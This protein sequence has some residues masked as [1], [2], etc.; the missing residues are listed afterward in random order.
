MNFWIGYYLFSLA[1]LLFTIFSPKYTKVVLAIYLFSIWFIGAFRYMYGADYYMYELLF[2]SGNADAVLFSAP[3]IEPTF[4]MMVDLYN[5][6]GLSY[7]A[8]FVTYET[9]ILFFFYKG[10]DVFFQ[11]GRQRLMMTLLYA[12]T[13]LTGGYF[14]GLNGMRQAAAM[15]ILFFASKYVLSHDLKRF[16]IF[17]TISVLFHYS[18]VLFFPIYFLSRKK[19]PSTCAIIG[20]LLSFCLT[21]TGVTQRIFFSVVSTL[22]TIYGK[23]EG[24]IDLLN[25][26]AGTFPPSSLF[27]LIVFLFILFLYYRDKIFNKDD[28]EISTYLYNASV[29]YVCFRTLMS[30]V[31]EGSNVAAI[32]HR[33]EIYFLF[34]FFAFIVYVLRVRRLYLQVGFLIVW[35]LVFGIV[36]LKS[37]YNGIYDP[38]I[39]IPPS[40]ATD[41]VEDQF[42]FELFR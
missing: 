11:T 24:Q 18:A 31:V 35:I 23:Y 12:T 36:N 15:S 2:E 37:F 28:C 38:L 9:I 22:A 8:M 20:V 16:I 14:F 30:F 25:V 3:S 27:T 29:V 26:D 17:F 1:A 4:Y 33:F 40:V 34:L 42:N 21:I 39:T 10:L 41:K 6:L 7:Q 13:T 32:I 5:E 19:I